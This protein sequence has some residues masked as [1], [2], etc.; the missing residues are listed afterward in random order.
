MKNKI[1]V[2]LILV[3]CTLAC[4]KPKPASEYL[5]AVSKSNYYHACVEKLTSVMIFDIFSPPV[6]SRIYS[7]ANLA[8][9][10]AGRHGDTKYKTMV[11]RI[12][13]FETV[14]QPEA[15]KEYCYPLASLKAFMTV[16]NNLTFSVEK[17]EAFEQKMYAE[18]D[19]LGVPSDVIER[20][21]AYGEAV[22][23]SINAY[24]KSDNYPQTRGLR[25]TLLNKPGTWSPTPPAY[26]DAV[27]PNWRSIR[28]MAMDSAAQFK[29]AP[30]IPYNAAAG[31]PFMQEVQEVYKK[32]NTLTDEEKNI[33]WFWD[34]NA[35]VMNVQG[36]VMFADKKMTPG[37]HWL[38]ITK[39][40]CKQ[41]K[42]DFMQTIQ[43][44]TLV[45][46]ALRDAFISCWDEKYR[47]NKIRPESIINAA[48][49]PKWVPFLQ[50][51]PFPEYTSGHS[52]ISAASAAVL[53]N[54]FGDNVAFTDSTEFKYGHG[55]RSFTSFKQAVEECSISRLY[56]GIHFK[57]AC[58]EGTKAG[59]KIGENV[60][61]KTK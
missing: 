14:A 30:V 45:S 22:G 27:E 18:F 60:L 48:V 32:G 54:L 49:D 39:T 29:P 23:K 33:A 50:T 42:T 41:Q 53:T 8:A 21:M 5:P 25:Y 2:L 61:M 56:G 52:T 47:S 7:Y 44:Y 59:Y 35:F 16:A 34:D 38:A 10:E 15:G 1:A 17:Y 43:A 57:S 36:H 9:Y 51:P 6:A 28:S 3:A 4:K 13:G 24:S 55:V 31:S 19:S 37:G 58:N 11:G 26:T 46:F 40:I 12:N 20:S